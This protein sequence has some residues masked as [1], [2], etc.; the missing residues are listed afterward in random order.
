MSASEM[1]I[2]LLT[3]HIRGEFVAFQ[4]L[5]IIL[6]NNFMKPLSEHVKSN[7]YASLIYCVRRYLLKNLSQFS[8]RAISST[9][10]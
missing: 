8:E 7:P 6:C 10:T 1:V 3:C 9:G 4:E 2:G 5:G